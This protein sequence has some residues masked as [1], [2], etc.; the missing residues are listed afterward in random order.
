MSVTRSAAASTVALPAGTCVAHCCKA[1]LIVFVPSVPRPAK[2]ARRHVWSS[3]VN[4]TMASPSHASAALS[5]V[6][7]SMRDDRTWNSDSDPNTSGLPARFSPAASFGVGTVW[8]VRWSTRVEG[9]TNA[10]S[11]VGGSSKSASTPL[12]WSFAITA[13]SI[14][15]PS[16]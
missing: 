8:N 2:V 4:V 1:A 9:V 16:T 11:A 5:A 6:A 13:S 12:S 10:A 7:L 14:D 15:G 3:R